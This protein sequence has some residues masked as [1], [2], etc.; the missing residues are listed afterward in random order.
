GIPLVDQTL[1][2]TIANGGSTAATIT[3]IW[4]ESDVSR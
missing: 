4:E 3:I 1:L 2:L